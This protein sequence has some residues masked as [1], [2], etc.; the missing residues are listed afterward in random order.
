LFIDH[1]TLGNS[2]NKKHRIFYLMEWN[3]KSL[4]HYH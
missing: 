1:A 2:H 4:F 3:K